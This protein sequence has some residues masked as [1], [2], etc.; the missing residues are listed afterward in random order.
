MVRLG[1]S[2]YGHAGTISHAQ[3]GCTSNRCASQSTR[4]GTPE[5]QSL[6][7]AL[8]DLSGGANPVL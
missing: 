1:I 3:D 2:T 6:E 8:H 7:E 5:V 4:E